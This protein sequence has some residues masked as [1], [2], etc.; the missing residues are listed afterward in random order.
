[1]GYVINNQTPIENMTATASSG[2]VTGTVPGTLDITAPGAGYITATITISPPDLSTGVQATATAT[3]SGGAITHVTI[4]GAGSGYIKIPSVTVTGTG[5]ITNVAG[6]Q[7][8][9]TPFNSELLPAHGTAFS[10]YVTK[11][12]ILTAISAG[13]RVTATAYSG[14]ESGFDIYFRT[15]L[16]TV[17]V[18]H[19]SL[20]WTIMNCDVSRN[21]STKI[22]EYFDYT[23]YLNNLPNFDVYDLKIVLKSTSQSVVP[24]IKSYNVITLAT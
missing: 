19:N 16:S 7:A 5:S 21:K 3:V 12:F 1:M 10:R 14:F 22:N 20:P 6:V 4:T 9:L 24:R 8:L 15:S 2:T 17:G 18:N 13:V 11:T 23:F